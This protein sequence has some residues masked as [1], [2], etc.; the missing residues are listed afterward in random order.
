MPISFP[1]T[2]SREF[3]SVFRELFVTAP[4]SVAAAAANVANDTTRMYVMTAATAQTL[5][6]PAD[7][8]EIEI[9]E[10]FK[11]ITTGAGVTTLAAGDGATLNTKAA[12]LDSDG[13]YSV[14]TVSKIGANA[15][16][17]SGDL[18]AA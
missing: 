18:A 3:M 9:G 6:I 14:I 8:D 2:S 11:V 7:L 10:S 12:T 1:I 4:V 5:T 16:I 17:A 15:Y 13:Q